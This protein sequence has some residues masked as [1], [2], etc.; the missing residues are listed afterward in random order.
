MVL[1]AWVRGI[2]ALSVLCSSTF[3]PAASL[4]PQSC[5]K[6]ACEAEAPQSM[7]TCTVMVPEWVTET[8]T[9]CSTEMRQEPRTKTVF[10]AVKTE[11]P[12]EIVETIVKRVPVTKTYTLIDTVFHSVKSIEVQKFLINCPR[13]ERRT[14]TETIYTPIT[15]RETVE[16]SVLIPYV[17]K[18]EGVRQR[19]RLE[20]Y[21]EMK[22]VTR[23]CGHYISVPY[24][25]PACVGCTNQQATTITQCRKV[26]V[27][28]LVQEQVPVKCFK[29]AFYS[30]NYTYCVTCYRPE[31][32]MRDRC[33]MKLCPSTRQ[34]D[35]CVLVSNVK[36][37]TR[38][39]PVCKLVPEEI[40]REVT[41]TECEI[42]TEDRTRIVTDTRCGY[43]PRTVTYMCNVPV[44]VKK[45][46]QVQVC[47]MVPK[48][49]QVPAGKCCN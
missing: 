31:T 18:R 17:E 38:E 41:R 26:W 44:V 22:T 4:R 12:K 23:D 42:Q 6:P 7:A 3:A 36:E 30:E 8:R 5:C 43:E 34:R 37:I 24:E 1:R 16:E 20:C 40:K 27:P 9:V 49:I 45:E 13:V 15:V 2:A 28:K 39:V 48:V 10:V 29:P 14:I 46:V 35:V 21:T 33:V 19:C 11:V 47:K 25:V 32:R